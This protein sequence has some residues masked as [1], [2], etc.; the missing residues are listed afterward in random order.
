MR[1]VTC[2]TELRRSLERQQHSQRERK[3]WETHWEGN[4]WQVC[5][6]NSSRMDLN[7]RIF[8]IEIFN[9]LKLIQTAA[10]VSQRCPQTPEEI[11]R[12]QSLDKRLR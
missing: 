12:A 3:Q 2:H 9:D 5:E 10:S 1:D 8:G 4:I 7:F 6:L 11:L